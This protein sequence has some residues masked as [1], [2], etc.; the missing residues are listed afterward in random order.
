M[1]VFHQKPN[2]VLL[3]LNGERLGDLNDVDVLDIQLVAA[4]RA[5]ILANGSHEC[6]RRFLRQGRGLCKL[7]VADGSLADHG[8]DIARSIPHDEELKF[9]ARA[10]MAQPSANRDVLT[11]VLPGI[12]DVCEGHLNLRLLCPFF[13]QF[14]QTNPSSKGFQGSTEAGFIDILAAWRDNSLS[15]TKG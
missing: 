13:K 3:R 4:R 8:L 5:L 1:P 2:A 12:L 15:R 11:D 9:A 10:A 14:L 6:Q 7:L